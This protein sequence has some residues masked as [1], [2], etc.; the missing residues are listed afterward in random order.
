MRNTSLWTVLAVAVPLL[1]STAH[2]SFA[3]PDNPARQSA[4]KFQPCPEPLT[5]IPT[6]RD[7]NV[8][9]IFNLD[10]AKSDPQSPDAKASN[11]CAKQSQPDAKNDSPIENALA[12]IRS[13]ALKFLGTPYRWGGTTPAAF[14]CSGFTRYVYNAFGVRLPRTAREQFKA[15]K[16]VCMSEL[17]AGDLLFF[18]MMKGYISHVG[19]YLG[20][21][22]FIHA[23]NPSSG[24]KISNLRDPS[25]KRCFVGARRY[26]CNN[27]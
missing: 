22:R 6:P 3:S 12:H 25:Y 19:M 27:V 7:E 17:K 23:S 21:G 26:N 18:D 13:M 14:D 24:V 10:D 4:D 5:D 11:V 15:G 16:P 2:Y 1:L 9:V 20:S 8:T